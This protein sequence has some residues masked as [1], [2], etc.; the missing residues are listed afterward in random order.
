MLTWHHDLEN[1]CTTAEVVRTARNFVATFSASELATVPEALLPRQIENDDDIRD[2]SRRLNDEY[3]WLRSLGG[4]MATTQELWS[5]F[6][7]ASIQLA[8]IG[9]ARH[10]RT[11]GS[12]SAQVV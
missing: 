2:C 8:R 3:W 7:R 10:E 4:E 6:L 9:A 1:A 5:F 11:F 12:R